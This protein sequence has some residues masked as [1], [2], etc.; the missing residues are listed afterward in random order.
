MSLHKSL[1][2]GGKLSRARNVLTRDERIAR[3]IEEG[4]FVE[5]ETPV[6]GLPKVRTIVAKVKKKKKKKE[7]ETGE[8]A[9]S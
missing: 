1:S 7:E 9:A 6:Y 8:T 3:L 5:G 2:T 4:R